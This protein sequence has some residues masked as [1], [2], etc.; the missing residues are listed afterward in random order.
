MQ[1]K[2]KCGQGEP[3]FRNLAFD[4]FMIS[5]SLVLCSWYRKPMQLLCKLKL[6]INSPALTQVSFFKVFSRR[7]KPY[8]ML[9][10]SLHIW[11]D[12]LKSVH[13]YTMDTC[14]KGKRSL[15]IFTRNVWLF[16]LQNFYCMNIM[17]IWRF[18]GWLK[19]F[20]NV[21]VK[22]MLLCLN[23]FSSA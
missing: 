18:N 5:R 19:Y 11:Y 13:A 23:R 4:F 17:I 6:K 16:I 3:F 12:L 8:G 1:F 10:C 2:N 7:E 9:T 22:L 14:G 15:C 20:R 21:P